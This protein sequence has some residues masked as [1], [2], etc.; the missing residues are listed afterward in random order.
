[1]ATGF[2]KI[3]LQFWFLSASKIAL[4]L[5]RD[6]P[7]FILSL[8]DRFF[9]SCIFV[10]VLIEFHLIAFRPLLKFIKIILNSSPAHPSQKPANMM[11]MCEFHKYVWSS[12]I[13]VIYENAGWYQDFYES[14]CMQLF[15]FVRKLLRTNFWVPFKL[16]FPSICAPFPLQF[17]LGQTT[18]FLYENI[19]KM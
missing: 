8:C 15:L 4:F 16:H 2:T 10:L 13:Q 14:S 7:A 3:G 11:V 17:Q 18:D 6:I 1:M 9:P 12:I 19:R 5:E